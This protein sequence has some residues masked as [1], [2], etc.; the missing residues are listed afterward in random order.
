MDIRRM[1]F[2]PGRY[3]TVM[4]NDLVRLVI[5]DKGGVEIEFSAESSFGGRINALWTPRFHAFPQNFPGG[6][7]ASCRKNGAARY[8]WAGSSFWYPSYG[9]AQAGGTD[10]VSGSWTVEKYG[11]DPISGGIWLYSSFR[12]AEEGYRVRRLDMLLKGQPVH[13]TAASIT[14]EGTRPIEGNAVKS[15]SLGFPFLQ[16]GCILNSCAKTWMT[17]PDD[18][19]GHVR[20]A[21]AAGI[22][23][24]DP[25]HVPLGAGKSG[26]YKRVPPVNGANDFVSG[27]VPRQ[28]PLGWSSVINARER[29]LFF[30]FFPGPGGLQED[31]IPVNFVNWNFVMGGLREPPW[32]WYDGG[33][34]QEVFLGCDVGTNMLDMGLKTAREKGTLMGV[35]TLVRIEPGRTKTFFCA[36]AFLPYE[37]THIGMGFFT[38]DRDARGLVLRRTKSTCPIPAEPEFDSVRRLSSQLL[39]TRLRDEEEKED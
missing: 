23:F 7:S 22:Q 9:L 24:D 27:R 16:N 20:R 12:N 11:T 36:K 25:A 30:T 8:C 2:W 37:A 21:M 10:T 38:V 17:P 6:G 26:N 32:A 1:Q 35:D 3:V 18:Q 15:T 13:Y 14:N 19:T 29:M 39:A 31:D 4:D 33:T 28:I 34:N 5:E